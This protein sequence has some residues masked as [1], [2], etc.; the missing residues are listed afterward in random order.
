MS[1]P[2]DWEIPARARPKPQ[3]LGIDLDRTLSGVFS[4]N[5]R[6]PGEVVAKGEFDGY[7]EY[8]LDEAIFTAPAHPNWGG[9]GLIGADGRLA[10]IGSLYLRFGSD[11]EDGRDGNMIVPI[12]LLPP[13][14]DDLTKFGRRRKPPRP[15]LG[16]YAAEVE[17]KLVVAGLA[18]GAPAE[19]PDLR[20][21]ATIT[22]IAADH[23]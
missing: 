1:E 9:T 5:A 19:K 14:L 23:H 16:F 10:G 15:W 2:V 11:K 4:L 8:V 6:I 7:W 20:V 22:A 3:D 13:I 12:D 21:R 17:D 18:G